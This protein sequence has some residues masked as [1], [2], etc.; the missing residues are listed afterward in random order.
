MC[1]CL[2]LGLLSDD[3]TRAHARTHAESSVQ[4]CQTPCLLLAVDCG[5][6]YLCSQSVG[7]DYSSPSLRVNT[8]ALETATQRSPIPALGRSLG[9]LLCHPAARLAQRH[10]VCRPP[11]ERE[12]ERERERT[13]HPSQSSSSSSSP[14]LSLSLSVSPSLCHSHQDGSTL[15]AEQK[16]TSAL[17]KLDS[18]LEVKR[19]LSVSHPPTPCP[20]PLTRSP[21]FFFFSSIFPPSAH[22]LVRRNPPRCQQPGDTLASCSCSASSPPR[23]AICSRSPRSPLREPGSQTG[24]VVGSY[25]LRAIE[26]RSTTSFASALKGTRR[27]ISRGAHTE[28]GV[29]P[30]DLRTLRLLAPCALCQINTLVRSVGYANLK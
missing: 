24:I 7:S 2:P 20:V 3:N 14:P 13:A 26:R 18:H 15:R 16:S 25:G 17:G 28:V 11:P 8:V 27:A 5:N 29:Y 6:V 9:P 19:E 23:R 22:Q 21:I 30:R 12:R 10:A 4:V 1:S